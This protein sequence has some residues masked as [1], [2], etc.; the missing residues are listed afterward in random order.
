MTFSAV[1]VG[2]RVSGQ[3]GGLDARSPLD[4]PDKVG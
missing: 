2:E 4:I 3:G 1:S